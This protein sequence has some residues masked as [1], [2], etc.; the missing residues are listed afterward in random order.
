MSFI[1]FFSL[2]T[3]YNVIHSLL[4]TKYILQC[5]SFTSF[6]SIHSTMSFIHFFSLNTFCHDIYFFSF[7]TFCPDI[8][9]FSLHTFWHDIH[10]FSQHHSFTP[11]NLKIFHYGSH[12]RSRH[13]TMLFTL[14]DS[15]ILPCHL[16]LPTSDILQHHSSTSFNFRYSAIFFFRHSA[17]NSLLF[18]FRHSAMNLLLFFARLM[19]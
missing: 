18:F 15:D 12:F 5:H 3:F 2:N 9:F 10:F 16:L 6:H 4:F 7:E 13:Y 19:P 1:H 14:F 17:M 11:F 8:H